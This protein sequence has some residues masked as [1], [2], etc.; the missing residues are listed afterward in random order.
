MGRSIASVA[1]ASGRERVL[2]ASPLQASVDVFNGVKVDCGSLDGQVDSAAFATLLSD[3]LRQWE[4][5]G[6][7]GCWLFIPSEK[8]HLVSAAVQQGFDFHHAKPGVV[9][10]TKWLLDTPNMIPSYPFTQVGVGAVIF[11]ESDQTLLTVVEKN[12][13]LKGKGVYKIPTGSAD[14][15]EHI[16]RAAER[17]V[18]EETGLKARFERLLLFRHRLGGTNCDLFFVCALKLDSSGGKEKQEIVVD[19][20]ELEDAKFMNIKDYFGQSIWADIKVYKDHINPVISSYTRGQY[21]GLAHH[22]REDER[23]GKHAVYTASQQAR[24]LPLLRPIR[25]SLNFLRR[26]VRP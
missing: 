17:E 18:W 26:L 19:E 24:P 6:R 21:T 7:S 10:M 15:G 11:D 22:V 20:S 23:Y 9:A 4:K 12:G 8:S 2:S 5:E 16:G 25:S 3:S 14:P 13:P 1:M